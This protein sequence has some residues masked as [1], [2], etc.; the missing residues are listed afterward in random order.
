MTDIFVAYARQDREAVRR[1]VNEL[2]VMGWDVWCDP[3]E[4]RSDAEDMSDVKLNA[5]G[6]VLVV[7][8]FNARYADHVRSEAATGLYR[9]RLVQVRID[10]VAPP[11]PFDQVEVIDLAGWNGGREGVAWQSMLSALR[12]TA[13]PPGRAPVQ[14]IREPRRK[15]GG[16]SAIAMAL[17]VLVLAGLA[18]GAVVWTF[19]PMGWRTDESVKEARADAPRPADRP[20]QTT[21]REAVV[22]DAGPVEELDT[23]T[24]GEAMAAGEALSSEI[25]ANT[26]TDATSADGLAAG[27]LRAADDAAWARALREATPAAYAAYLETWPQGWH[28]AD[29]RAAMLL[30]AASREP[31]LAPDVAS[32]VNAAREAAAQGERQSAAA[33]ARATE[34]D[35]AAAAAARGDAGFRQVTTNGFTFAGRTAS[36]AFTG[37]GVRSGAAGEAMRYRGDLRNGVASGVGVIE[38]APGGSGALRYEGEI[39]ADRPAGAGLTVWSNGNLYAGTASQGSLTYGD[40]RRYEGE[41]R[42]GAPEGAGALWSADGALLQAGRWSRG[43]AVR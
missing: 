15:G 41:M 11:R 40:G 18:A 8:S 4:P 37:P 14:P 43:Q 2:A 6:A 23:A 32:A 5:A 28:V 17:S 25:E 33:R 27:A 9:N 29:A 34:A 30:P 3:S 36:G 35:Q 16:A 38:F 21:A 1:I 42:D 12:R 26:Q 10:G 24:S 22:T 7:W 19:D 31:V 13:G 20:V 39:A